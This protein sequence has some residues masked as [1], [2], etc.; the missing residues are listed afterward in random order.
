MKAQRHKVINASICNLPL[1]KRVRI[2]LT[3]DLPKGYDETLSEKLCAF[4]PEI[5]L[6]DKSPFQG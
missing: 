1:K 5:V 3:L 6:R 4:V 2:I